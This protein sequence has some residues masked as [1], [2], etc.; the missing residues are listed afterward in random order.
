MKNPYAIGK[1]VYLRPP[2]EEDLDSNWYTWLTDPEI[3]QYLGDRYWPN[4]KEKQKAFYES[5]KD[6]TTRLVLLVIDKTTDKL[7]GV[8]NFNNISFLHGKAEIALIIGE[9]EYRKGTHAIDVMAQLLK[10]GFER[11]N[12]RNI[13]TSRLY[14]NKHTAALEKLFGFKQVGVFE[15]L[16]FYKGGYEDVVYSQLTRE[17]WKERNQ[18]K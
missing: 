7:I 11:L 2:E 9:K 15:G 1:S 13:L 4:T 18:N 10:V 8:C 17:N 12:L 16:S 6:A 5:T 14:I 3:T